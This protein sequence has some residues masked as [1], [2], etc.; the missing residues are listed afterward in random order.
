[1][2]CGRV[3]DKI[4]EPKQNKKTKQMNTDAVEFV[5]IRAEE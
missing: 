4:L 2:I 1:M 5:F 3:R